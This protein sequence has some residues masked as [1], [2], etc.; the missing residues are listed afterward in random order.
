MP[1][2]TEGGTVQGPLVKYAAEAGWTVLA[3][4]DAAALRHGE[5]GLLLHD[6]FVQR[7][8]ALNPGVIDLP[9]AEDVAARLAKVSPTIEGNEQAW[10]YLRGL[11][12]VYVPEEKR[13]RNVRLLDA[14]HPAANACHVTQELTFDNGTHRIRADVVF[15]VN[16][17]PVII[18][19]AKAAHKQGAIAEALDQVRRYHREA[20]ELLAL[21]QLHTLTN[22][23]DFRY[24]ATWVLS[25]KYL[26]SWRAEQ[27]G[28]YE[29]LVKHFLAPSRVL[30]L[31]T[32]FILFTRKDDE[33]AKVVLRPH[34]MRA[35]ERSLA[36]ARD[37]QK[38][39]ALIWHTQGSGKTYT[40]IT[41]AKR[42]IEDPHLQNPT[43]LMLVDRNELEAQ[44]F[45]NLEATG[46]GHVELAQSKRHL[47]ALLAGDRRGLI[48]SLIH[49]FDGMPAGIN[50]R[51]TIYVLVDEAHRTTNGDLG[52]YL[53]GALPNATYIGFTGTP[54]DRTAHGQGTFKV[55]GRDDEPGY[56][57]KYAIAESVR[58]GTTVP[59]HYA[60][61]RNDLLVDRDTLNREFLDLAELEGVSDP[62]LLDKVLDRAVT[63]TNM[64]KNRER[65]ACV[66]QHVAAHYRANVEPMGYKAFLV[67]VDREACALYKQALDRYLPPEYSAVVYSA[68]HNDS[69]LLAQYHLSEDQEKEVRRRF[70]KAEQQPR[71]L[72]V[73]DKLLTGFDAPILYCLYL[74]KPMRDHV[75][76]QAIARVNRPYEDGEGRRKAAGLIYD[77]VGIFGNL[78]KAL[79][80]DSKDVEGVVQGLD[81]LQVR[82][83]EL[84]ALG[85]SQYLSIWAG[86]RGDKAAEAVLE[87]FRDEARRSAFYAFFGELEDAYEILSPD[88]FLRPYLDDY[89]NLSQMYGLVRSAFERHVLVDRE[90]L[91]KTAGLVQAHTATP[92][93]VDPKKLHRIDGQVLQKLADEETA[94]TVKVFNLVKALGALVGQEGG[95]APHLIPIGERAEAIARAFEERLVSAQEAL[96][97]LEQLVREYRE[98]VQ[99]REQSDLSR[100]GFGVYWLLKNEEVAEAEQVAR[101]VEPAFAQ[102]PHWA[103]SDAQERAV[104]LAL[105]KALTPTSA[106]GKATDVVNRILTVLRRA[107][108]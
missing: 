99:Q 58:D 101:T 102:H 3:P 88:P 74:D 54:I 45:A 83:A 104:R 59:L 30:R 4:Y 89:L 24:G 42:L 18:L 5:G 20:P 57:D 84:M 80:F 19:E 43:V 75:L 94:D 37:P 79:A 69:A 2:L 51:R 96:R 40:M 65:I 27:A 95:Q 108:S 21:L 1:K 46:F 49:K 15:F 41:V 103:R 87:H 34:Q 25:G 92:A 82:F 105:Y 53:M 38:R 66:A 26:F 7:L 93:I 50:E 14:A 62:E 55:F 107:I 70:L 56:L 36:R 98:A 100:E 67:A 16:G 12:T 78:K 28:D 86:R 63:L 33:L 91:R 23:V 8:Q 97:Q 39:R 44:L 11:R 9:R 64:L 73:T 47:Q 77:F 17:V 68:A 31:L 6:V 71:I 61:A 81:V 22:L 76:L 72:I 60:L 106:G 52:N 35:V 85:R 10:Q 29:T 48:V 13:E 90:F 32:Q